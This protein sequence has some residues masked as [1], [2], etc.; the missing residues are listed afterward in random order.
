M[1]AG[2]IITEGRSYPTPVAAVPPCE[3]SPLADLTDQGTPL[4]SLAEEGPRGAL[5]Q[6]H[7]TAAASAVSL[8][9]SQEQKGG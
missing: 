4:M 5:H 7:R 6:R 8:A 1:Q 2:D 9:G 3:R